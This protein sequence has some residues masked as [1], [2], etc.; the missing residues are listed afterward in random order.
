M[1]P[2]P[3]GHREQILRRVAVAL[4]AIAP[5]ATF[6]VP[7]RADGAHHPITSDLGKRV[8]EK[9]VPPE[10]MGNYRMPFLCVAP[11]AGQPDRMA[12]A[13]LSVYDATINLVVVG[14]CSG[15]GVPSAD[16]YVTARHELNALADDVLI[17]MEAVPLITD[18]DNPTPLLETVG[19]VGVLC[20]AREV[21]EF[22]DVSWG[23]IE[24]RFA[25]T[26]TFDQFHP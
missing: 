3:P 12:S 8:I 21:Q 7:L 18:A 11:E 1:Q 16:A 9:M 23:A 25:L 5:A 26:Y 13:D 19:H 24:M 15:R 17:A 22:D 14:Y 20:T 6:P 10:A 4:K 2:N